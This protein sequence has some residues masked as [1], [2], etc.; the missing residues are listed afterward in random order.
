MTEQL[1]QCLAQLEEVSILAACDPLDPFVD[2]WLVWVQEATRELQQR[3]VDLEA[4]IESGLPVNNYEA[5][6]PLRLL[7]ACVDPEVTRLIASF[8]ME[9]AMA[10]LNGLMTKIRETLTAEQWLVKAENWYALTCH[11]FEQ[12]TTCILH[13]FANTG[14][15]TWKEPKSLELLKKM[16][17][18]LPLIFK[19]QY[20]PLAHWLIDY[21][22]LEY[23]QIKIILLILDDP[24]I[25]IPVNLISYA[26]CHEDTTMLEVLLKDPRVIV[27][28]VRVEVNTLTPLECGLN[29]MLINTVELLLADPRIEINSHLMSRIHYFYGQNRNNKKNNIKLYQQ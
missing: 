15:S 2:Q 26:A 21:Y 7:R 28:N 6:L 1:R 19:Y 29:Y 13:Q 20:K 22:T 4:K 24:E 25:V 27:P 11:A 17:E 8:K 3:A 12:R 18:D 10:E 14:K 5:P 9:E 23:V 16:V